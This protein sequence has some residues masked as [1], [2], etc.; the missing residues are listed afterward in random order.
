MALNEDYITIG[1]DIIGASFEVMK[2]AGRFMRERYYEA[3]LAYEL[4]QRGYDVKRQ[5]TIPALYKGIQV[6]DSYIADVVV[7]GRVIIEIKA[8][9]YM[10]DE[11]WRQL[12]SYLKLSGFKLGYLINFGAK[13]FSVGK[14]SEKSPYLK[15]IYRLVNNI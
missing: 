10:K 5:V 2:N 1:Q 7:D 8:I 12:M 9:P 15:G 11:E 3:S 4:I 6:E 14:S 13:D